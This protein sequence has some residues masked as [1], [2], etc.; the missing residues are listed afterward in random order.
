MT[1]SGGRAAFSQGRRARPRLEHCGPVPFTL[2]GKKAICP[3]SWGSGF[4]PVPFL[5][6]CHL[7]CLSHTPKYPF[8]VHSGTLGFRGPRARSLDA[9][10]G[11]PAHPPH[12]AGGSERSC[13]VVAGGGGVGPWLCPAHGHPPPEGA[14][15]RQ[16]HR[17]QHGWPC[18]QTQT[19]SPLGRCGTPPRGRLC[20][21]RHL[22]VLRGRAPSVSWGAV[23]H[24]AARP[25]GASLWR[26]GGGSR[27]LAR[28]Q[29]PRKTEKREHPE[30]STGNRGLPVS[31]DQMPLSGLRPRAAPPLGQGSPSA[32]T[33]ASV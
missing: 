21:C 16:P 8:A 27:G 10:L 33:S 22:P 2:P 24:S 9:S 30:G 6:F 13:G 20:P 17:L 23:T 5:D 12:Q 1:N 29:N 3:A 14:G 11:L 18:V 32:K 25:T 31:S 4:W 7:R 26:G 15:W 28:T 19:W